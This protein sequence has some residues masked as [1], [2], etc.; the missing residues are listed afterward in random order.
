MDFK[1]MP[2]DYPQTALTSH[3]RGAFTYEVG[4]VQGSE[5]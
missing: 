3:R 2:S 1:R 5:R 4:R